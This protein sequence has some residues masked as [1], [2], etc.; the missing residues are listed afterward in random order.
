MLGILAWNW[1]FLAY[2]QLCRTLVQVKA[3]NSQLDDWEAAEYAESV[4]K[5]EHAGTVTMK[6]L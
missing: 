1:F 3:V 2:C 5:Q 6:L 4:W